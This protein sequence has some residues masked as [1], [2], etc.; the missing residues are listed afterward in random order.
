MRAQD[1]ADAL[2]VLVGD[3]RVD[4]VLGERHAREG[5]R[6]GRN[7]LRRRGA[8]AG[9]VRSRHRPLLDGPDRLARVA[10]EDVDIALLARLRDDVDLAAVAADGE[11]LRRLWEIEVPEIVMNRLE[12]PEPLTGPGIEGENA[13]AEQIVAVAIRTVEVVA[14]GARRHEHD[15]ALDVDGR[16]APVVHAAESVRGVVRPRIRAELPGP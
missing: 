1:L 11:Q 13:V 8:L 12:V 5:R 16:L 7:R 15:A 6:C 10:L 9:H 4:V 14:R 2:L 3:V